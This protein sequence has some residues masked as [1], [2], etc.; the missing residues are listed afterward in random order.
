[1]LKM[2]S[3]EFEGILFLGLKNLSRPTS[4]EGFATELLVKAQVVL[5]RRPLLVLLPLMSLNHPH[6][7]SAATAVEPNWAT[8][9]LASNCGLR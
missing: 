9:E 1:M 6:E 4:P 8:T 3:A 2:F 5:R 7:S